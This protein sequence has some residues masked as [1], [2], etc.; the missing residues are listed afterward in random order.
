M[1]RRVIRILLVAYAAYLALALF[2]LLPAL[3]V[4]APLLARDVLQRELRSELILFNPFTL[5][6]E[7]RDA[8]L[9]EPDGRPFAALAL[10]RVD[11]GALG[12]LLSPGLVLDDV[13]IEE[14]AVTLRRDGSGTLNIADLLAGGAD[15][16]DRSD[17]GAAPPALT[18]RALDF[19]ARE[20]RFVDQTRTP[21]YETAV[22]D[23]DF[24]V[25]E[26]STAVEEGSPY[27]LLLVTE[28]NGILRWRGELSLARGDSRG[29]FQVA[30]LDLRPFHR[31]L[32]QDLAFDLESALL[33][34]TGSYRADWSAEP[35]LI[36]TDGALQ[37]RE[38][39]VLPRDRQALAGT[40]VAL[41]RLELDDITVD[42]G[43]RRAA[44][45]ELLVERLDTRAVLADGRL[46]LQ[47]L[48]PMADAE[49]AAATATAPA[50]PT[51]AD[52]WQ[53]ALD[54]AAV[55]GA[56]LT[57][58]NDYT[59][60]ATLAVT[61]LDLELRD[62]SYPA[63]GS[64]TVA[65]DLTL[66][67]DSRLRVDGRIDTGSGS[68]SLDY[69]LE[70]LPLPLGNPALTELVNADV[71]AGS[72][73]L[74]GAADFEDF[75]PA[76]VRATVDVPDFSL[77]IHGREERA[78]SWNALTVPDIDLDLPERRLETGIVTLSGYRGR[79]HI[80]DDGSINVQLALRDAPAVPPVDESGTRADGGAEVP[81]ATPWDAAVAGVEIDDA[82]ID[83]ED[84]SLPLSFRTLIEGIG[85]SIGA[86]ATRSTQPTAVALN[87]TV[88]G[89]APV[90]IAGAV[91]PFA[92]AP[93]VAITV[94][95]Q[96]IDIARLTPYVGTY[97]GYRVD[98][99]TLNLDL[100]Y[101]LAGARLRGDNRA[102]ISQMQLGAPFD[103]ERAV[104]L[105]LKLAIALL[106]DSRGIIDLD[107]PVE[108][109]VDDPSFRL[110]KVIGRA[111]AN[112]I[113][114]IATAPF[115][116]LAS[117]A[118]SK[119]DLRFVAFQ[120]GEA[121]L[122]APAASKLDALAAAL[123]KRPALRLLALGT[124]DDADLAALRAATLREQLLAAGL[125]ADALAA[126]DE[127]WAAAIAERYVA[128]ATAPLPDDAELP[129]PDAQYDAVVAAVPVGWEALDRLAKERATAVK[130]HLV[131]A[132]GI[133]ADR[134]AIGGSAPA[135]GAED[136]E[137]G[138]SL[139]VGA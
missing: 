36:L 69:A 102:V 62:L 89:Y 59:Q 10:L 78:V 56:S 27:E 55:R 130:R 119:E 68:G 18:I 76:Q 41:G 15:P 5:A 8:Q 90:R 129:A 109:D 101:S 110:G 23:I 30:D 91:A 117:L 12:S 50:A 48:V 77:L 3:N 72:L 13:R 35:R 14:L 24:T 118:G 75:A 19:D 86:V 134:I 2:V 108:G 22:T 96:G 103:S 104:K 85:G 114:N 105:P 25:R 136:S 95:F 82:S 137:G 88:D 131:T 106:K 4:A 71:V 92:P 61:P 135:Q 99:G 123:D 74:R 52:A 45:R 51:G 26:L 31:Y 17:T 81:E 20:L 63:A 79:L 132:G 138:V 87:G 38:L 80:L 54:R 39:S 57:L 124:T 128:L 100:D 113:T 97:A 28:R 115:K 112:V 37:L 40:G 53:F 84:D 83:F 32:A 46:S 49:P 16:A 127:R 6:I 33:E 66:N 120:A 44:A 107:V 139:E 60:P 7:I 111:I 47:A 98:S 29:D 11:F 73:S 126:R 125:P 94:S 1:L 42:S 34:L 121:A 67:G 43:A 70:R 64:S 122:V 58:E 9:S 21:A 65:L 93:D 116:L 133:A